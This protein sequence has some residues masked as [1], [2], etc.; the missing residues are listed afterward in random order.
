M[1][2]IQVSP[3]GSVLTIAFYNKTHTPPTLYVWVCQNR[4][5]F[6][7]GLQELAESPWCEIVHKGDSVVK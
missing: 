3:L 4:E 6:D 7:K 1:P 5:A 2:E